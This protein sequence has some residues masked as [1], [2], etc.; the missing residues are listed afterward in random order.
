MKSLLTAAILVCATL[1]VEAATHGGGKFG[2]VP[3]PAHPTAGP[4]RGSSSIY[5]DPRGAPVLAPDRKV[6]EQDCTKP[7][8]LQAGN[9]RCK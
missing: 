7:V 6:S 9:L 1:N 2:S 4:G 8:D 5:R 3:S